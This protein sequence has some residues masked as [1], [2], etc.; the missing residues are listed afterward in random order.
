VR[1]QASFRFRPQ[2]RI[3]LDRELQTI[4]AKGRRAFE[5]AFTL[6]HLQRDSGIPR[7]ALR[8][9]KAFG[10]SPERNRIR[11]LVREA[12][13]HEKQ[14]LAL[15]VDLVVMVRPLEENKS[16]GSNEVREIF[17]SLCRTVNIYQ[18]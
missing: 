16:L 3:R 9:P 4:L 2:E 17:V 8:V 18:L 15:G 6:V 7:L 5:R 1:G 14:N 11:R 10:N 12:F 13:R